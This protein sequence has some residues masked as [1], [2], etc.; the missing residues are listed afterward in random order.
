MSERLQA[1]GD[2]TRGAALAS[3]TVALVLLGLKAYAAVRTGSVAML[4]SLAD[5]GLDLIA[6]LITLYAVHLAAQPAD[7]EHRFGHG[8]AEAIAALF[9]TSLILVSAAA[10]AWRAVLRL[11][12]PVEPAQAELGI[13]VSLVAIAMTLALVAY[14]RAV[15]RRTRSLA[16]ET[17]RLHYQSDLLLN[18][19]VIAALALEHYLALRGADALF[20]LGIAVYLA[21]GAFWSA[22]EAL[23]M[24]MDREWPD[25]RRDELRRIADPVGTL[26]IHELRT[27]RSGATDFIQ[28]HMYLAPETSV[29]D[30]HRV[31]DE[32][33]ARV[34]AAFPGAEILIHVDPIGHVDPGEMPG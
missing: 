16:I 21:V 19:S 23:D 24:L 11:L 5:T 4:G 27:R 31:I 26:G 22:R 6:S 3:V 9:Q 28:F 12:N 29:R 2:A 1:H 18:V 7:R 34:A 13:G 15:V 17:D 32:V 20:G 33:E 30:A 14:Q 8:K 25:E 10:I